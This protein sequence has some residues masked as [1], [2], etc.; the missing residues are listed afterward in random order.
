[1]HFLLL[2]SL[3][4]GD[5]LPFTRKPLFLIIDSDNAHVFEIASPF[6]APLV[7]FTSAPELPTFLQ[8]N[9]TLR[10]LP[11]IKIHSSPIP[12]RKLEFWWS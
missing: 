1:M 8:G 6:G 12:L 11:R 4:P 3:H 7:I 5:I 2:R 9:S 10:M